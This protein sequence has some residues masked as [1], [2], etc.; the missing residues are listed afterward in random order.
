[1]RHDLEARWET[2]FAERTHLV[3][4]GRRTR[5]RFAFRGLQVMSSGNFTTGWVLWAVSSYRNAC[6][7]RMHR[8][9]LAHENMRCDLV[10]GAAE[11]PER[12]EQN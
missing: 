1:M 12:R 2:W 9:G 5:L 3:W 11:L 10:F 8:M 7:K 6:D 4:P